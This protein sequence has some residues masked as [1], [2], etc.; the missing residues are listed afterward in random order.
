MADNALDKAREYFAGNYNCAQAVFRTILE[1]K[2]LYFDQVPIVAAGFG[3]GISRRGEVCGIVNGAVMAIGILYGQKYTEPGEH[4]KYTYDSVS[5]LIQIFNEI[6][7][8]PICNELIGFDIRDPD[9]RTKGSEEGVFKTK[10]PKYVEDAVKIVLEMF[11][12]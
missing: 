4:R 11:P 3:G 5:E 12:D 1:E 7:A 10:C 6:N 9:A 2:E 8:S